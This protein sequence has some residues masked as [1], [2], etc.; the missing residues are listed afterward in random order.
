VNDSSQYFEALYH[1]NNDPWGYDLHWYEA[2][3]RQICLALLTQSV[4]HQCWKSA[5]PMAI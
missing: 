5:V 4:I 3:K 1:H 2:R